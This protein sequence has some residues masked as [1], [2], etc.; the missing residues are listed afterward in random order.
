MT[1]D[2]N[3]SDGVGYGKPPIGNRFRKGQSGNPRG[4]PKGRHKKLPYETVLGQLVTIGED[5]I[6]RMVTAEE[7]FLLKLRNDALN[8]DQKA[9]RLIGPALEAEQA[10]R[11]EQIENEPVDIEIRP[12]RPGSVTP[13][14]RSLRIATKL[15]A[16]RKTA[17]MALE[18]WI[19]TAALQRFGDKRLSIEE[20]KIVLNATRT[21]RKVKWPEWWEALP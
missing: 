9:A 15:D 5:G 16:F 11:S 2:E 6:E 21:P 19:I 14:L 13:A 12:V 10:R 17:R 7:A 18:P 8:G 3:R 20:Q 4:R 1:N